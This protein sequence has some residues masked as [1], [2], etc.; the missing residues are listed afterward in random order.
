M[1]DQLKDRI[2][3]A[4]G[5]IKRRFMLW[6]LFLLGVALVLNTIAGS[7][8]T[9]RQI[10]HASA[11][12]QKEM[13]SLT[14][15]RIRSL[16]ERKIERLQDTGIAMSLHPLGGQE[17]KLLGLLLLKNDPSFIEFSVLDNQ[18]M[19]LL[20]SSERRVYLTSELQDRSASV[21][22]LK[23]TRDDFYISS[24]RTSDRAE[25][26][27]TL[28]VPLRTGP[29]R[30]T[31]V[32]IA[33]AHLKFLWEIIA[34]SRF[35]TGGYAYLVDE[36]G[37]LIA[38]RDASLVLKGL[39]LENLP[40]IRRFLRNRSEDGLPGEEGTGITGEPV[41]S[42]YAP[43]PEL[44][45]AVVVEEPVAL[46]LADLDKLH[47][48]ALL[49]LGVGL[50]VGAGIIVGLSRKITKPIQELRAGAE[51][52]GAGNLQHRAII[53]T[54]DE[55]EEL[56][57]EFNKM[58]AALQNSYATLEQKVE[59]RTQEVSAL[60]EVTTAV[61]KSLDVQS[62]LDAVIAKVTEIFHFQATRIF[63]FNEAMDELELRASF[64]AVPIHVQGTRAFKLD[65]ASLGASPTRASRSSSKTF[66]PIRAMQ[67]SARRRRC[68]PRI[69]IF[70]RHSR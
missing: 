4:H 33:E 44:G 57:D 13:A 3:P 54:G 70:S 60:Y 8:Y 18:G 5:S 66:G 63:L 55:I 58:A 47:H 36:Q 68:K 46:A 61:N 26:Y 62:I 45:W 7:I 42:A 39:N 49:L 64:E 35:G 32:L 28:A 19:E 41:L 16:I 65:R 14:A 21:P 11:D 20:K 10:R 15:R 67:L 23:A 17:Q 31:G 30:L 48:Y 38:H 9:R 50:L 59:Q 24:V 52:I 34:E 2:R 40:K 12:L 25:P 1:T 56:A 29:H 27:V 53:K 22:F 37:K 6:G 51:I 43:V 69:G